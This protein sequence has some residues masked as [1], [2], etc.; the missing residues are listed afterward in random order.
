MILDDSG[1]K[2]MILK[3]ARPEV[4]SKWKILVYR[5]SARELHPQRREWVTMAM[6]SEAP[7]VCRL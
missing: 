4:G 6:E 5:L 1:P 7:L 2:L 3:C